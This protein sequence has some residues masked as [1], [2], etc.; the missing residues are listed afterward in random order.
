MNCEFFAIDYNQMDDWFVLW[1]TFSFYNYEEIHFY[2][3]AG[4]IFPIL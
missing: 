4:A 1:V 3:N 2:P